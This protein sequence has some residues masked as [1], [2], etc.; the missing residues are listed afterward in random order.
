MDSTNPATYGDR[1]AE[2][3][4]DLHAEQL[5]DPTPAVDALA[6]LAGDRTVLELGI[7]TGRIAIPLAERGVPIRGIDASEAMVARLRAK[8]GGE[9]IP[10]TIGDFADVPVDD[11]FGLIF[12]V[13]N[14][15]FALTSQADQ[16]R[17]LRNVAAHLE[18]GG[19]FALEAFVPDLARF[20]RGQRTGTSAISSDWVHVEHSIHHPAE[21]RVDALHVI[22]RTGGT[23]L[24]PVEIRYAFPA[25]L[26]LMAELA[27]LRPAHRWSGWD[28]A[29]FDDES[30]GHVSVWTKPA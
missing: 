21:Q 1:I 3:Y 11:T 22:H 15:L 14:T 30:T 10:V 16:V 27:G 28:R 23:S 9:T 25:E 2:V 19:A 24:Y 17:C 26:D 4:D 18:P 8:P 6:E 7:G 12:I 20:D 29:S 13:F 5:G